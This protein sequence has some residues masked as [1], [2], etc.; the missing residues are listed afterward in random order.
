MAVKEQRQLHRAA[1]E[2][3]DLGE[4]HTIL[5]AARKKR[6]MREIKKMGNVYDRL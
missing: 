2:A 5:P 3:V 6:P 1:R 4:G